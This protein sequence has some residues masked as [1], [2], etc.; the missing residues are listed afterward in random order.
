VLIT[1]ESFGAP[2]SF[3]QPMK[4]IDVAMVL[5]KTKKMFRFMF[6]D[7]AGLKNKKESGK[8]A[9]F[10][11]VRDKVQEDKLYFDYRRRNNP[12]LNK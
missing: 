12:K 9:E 2:T 3:W 4:R 8:K 7:L 6:W 5:T 10:T 11:E 1:V